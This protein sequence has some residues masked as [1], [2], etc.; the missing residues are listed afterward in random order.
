MTIKRYVAATAREA[1]REV[2]RDLSDEA[3]ILSN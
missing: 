3:M 1:M 2:R